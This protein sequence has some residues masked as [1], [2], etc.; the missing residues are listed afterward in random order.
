MSSSEHQQ[1]QQQQLQQ[2]QQQ[3]QQQPQRHD[4]PSYV[5]QLALTSTTLDQFVQ[6][7]NSQASE[8]GERI[9]EVSPNGRYAKLNVVLGKGF[10]YV[11]NERLTFLQVLTKSYP[12]RSTGRKATKSH[13]TVSRPLGKNSMS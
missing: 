12:K 6:A 13:G 9:I 11:F 2:L 4:D 3:Q 7:F 1:Q 8:D 5:S 10:T